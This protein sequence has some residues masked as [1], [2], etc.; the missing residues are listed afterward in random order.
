MK[1]LI[2]VIVNFW[3]VICYAQEISICSWNI[4]DFGNSKNEIEVEFIAN[5]LKIYDIIAI[6]EVVAGP[7]GAQAVARLSDKLNRK[8]AKWDFLISPAT[9]GSPYTRERYAFLWKTK[10]VKV[11]D[12]GFLVEKFADL[13]DREPFICRFKIYGKT[14][15]MLTF[16][17]TTKAKQPEAEIKYFKYLNLMF[18]TKDWIMAGDFNLS[19]SHSV[20]NPIKKQGII[21]A[22]IHQKTSLKQKE[23][24]G[25]HLA[26]E[27][28]NIFYSQAA[29][30]LLKSGIVAT[31]KQFPELK[32][33]REISD[34]VPIYVRLKLR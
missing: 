20:F 19:Q 15:T 5:T 18:N 25:E 14:L 24:N 34:H 2:F 16:H 31:Y 10:E 28:D 4:K 3:N 13:I 9:S 26:S 6:Q 27:L 29:F 11:L 22:L 32:K 17:A 23:I 30:K 1:W 7:G 21:P 12:K 33:A 8:G